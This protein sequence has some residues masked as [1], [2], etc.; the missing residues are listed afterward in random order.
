MEKTWDEFWATGKVTDYLAY[1]NV[2]SDSYKRRDKET[3]E[4]NGTG[5]GRDGYGFDCH[6]FR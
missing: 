6:A 4:D 5:S 1:R 2:V 3:G